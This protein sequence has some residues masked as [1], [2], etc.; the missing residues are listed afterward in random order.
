MAPQYG[1]NIKSQ[2]FQ[3]INTIV[4]C[5][6]DFVS[7]LGFNNKV[8]HENGS[9][10]L[11]L[12]PYTDINFQKKYNLKKANDKFM[13][14]GFQ[15][16]PIED[17]HSGSHCAY[18]SLIAINSNDEFKENINKYIEKKGYIN[19]LNYSKLITEYF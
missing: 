13:K 19:Y 15:F 11:S 16:F 18:G 7:N 2:T 14:Y 3:D 12:D 4:N 17:H 5:L 8:D 1:F 9:I 10:V 6:S